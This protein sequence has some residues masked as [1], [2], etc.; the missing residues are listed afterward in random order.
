MYSYQEVLEASKDYFNG[1][2]LSAKVFVDKYALRNEKDELLELTPDDMHRRLAKEFA[3]IE[4][5]K[6]K[7][8]YTE[9]QIYQ[10]FKNY[11]Q[12]IP[13]GSPIYGIG[14]PY[15]LTS[16]SNCFVLDEPEDSYGG[17]LHV[18]EQL[19]HISKRRG[20]VGISLN[21]LR[22]KGSRTHNAARSSTGIKSWMTRYSNSIREVGQGGRRGAL[23]LTLNIHHPDIEDFIT[24]KNDE[25]SVTGANISVQLTDEFLTAVQNDIEYEQRFPINAI[26]PEISIKVKA[27]D[28]WKKIIHNAWMRA[29]PGLQ[30]IDNVLRES[31]ADC[32]WMDGYRTITSNPCIGGES[33][34]ITKEYGK[35]PFKLLKIG[36]EIWS[37]TGWTKVINKKAT[38]KHGLYKISTNYGELYCTEDHY[39]MDNGQKTRMAFT[40][41]IDCFI[42]DN[43]NSNDIC[44]I[45][46]E[47]ILSCEFLGEAEVFDITVD[48]T[49]NT[50]WCGG[51]NVSNCG[52]LFLSVLDSCRLLAL[53][54]F[55]CVVNPFQSNAYFDYKK[56]YELSQIGQRLMDNLVDL[57]L[58]CIDK[59]LDKVKSD[60]EP[61]EIRQRE[62]D[63]WTRIR[64]TCVNGRRTGLGI[65][66]LGD[67]LAALGV[68]YGSPESIQI[69][70]EIY[71]ALKFGSYRSSVDMAKELG[72]FPIW[73]WQKEKDNPFINR[74]KDEVLSLSKDLTYLDLV[75]GYD[76]YNDI[77]KYGRRNIAD[78]TT[79]PTGTI[80]TQASLT[81]NTIK[82]FDT[83]KILF[84]T[85]SGIEPLF[86][87][88]YIR[89][90]K[91]NP[92]DKDFRVDF[93]D[94]TGDSWMEFP[95]YHSGVKMWMDITGETDL[96]KCPYVE[97]NDVIWTERV[98]M[99][100]AA[101]K[102]VDHSISV[103][104][105]LPEDITEE[106]V[107]KIYE[108]AWK[109]G[110]KGFT[111]YR[112][113][114]RSGVLIDINKAAKNKDNLDDRPK[115]LPC[116][117]YHTICGGKQYFVL[118]GMLNEKPYEVF[119]GKNGFISKDVT[120][121]TIIK[122]AKRK[123]KVVFE[124]G[125]ELS[126]ITAA[127]SEYE[128]TITRLTSGLLRAGADI[129]TIVQQLERVNG[130]MHSF[131]KGLARVLKKYIPDGTK[132][133]GET[134]PECKQESIIRSEGCITCK[135]CS[136]S[137]C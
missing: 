134:C 10:W 48:N 56:L 78:L 22:P 95:V 59:I 110:C 40:K 87:T 12:I 101:Q 116:N 68:K 112:E 21:K 74:I 114:C 137:K 104:C 84:N 105:N 51:C 45:K 38:G 75:N 28:V 125:E 4:S 54:L 83:F 57:E 44:V 133:K 24:A 1:E 130:D 36:D 85:T 2:E 17:I 80:S 86:K 107:A 103:T 69:T 20:G 127:T 70:E 34:V 9:D 120:K 6:F 73:D 67:T 33:L 124:D 94:K 106:E 30:F 37:E 88:H 135:N 11:S 100:A 108:E 53:N 52:E 132:E 27:R 16:I 118:V 119:S 26:Q 131:A 76:L 15:Q 89:R 32:Y 90:K 128:E 77:Q 13:Q 14:N 25:T 61:L 102:H 66:V 79:A 7:E 109:S 97:A 55:S 63:T 96:S 98:K 72:P 8:P 99:Q 47:K 19:V 46:N 58:E 71:K 49:T 60:P 3:R 42:D 65:T 64:E 113:N 5:K 115:E 81:L 111:I 122:V 62:I 29:E 39:V 93:V 91:G 50:F 126:P 121:G 82:P 23:M 35:I 41:T 123:Y 43:T 31:P 129:Q 117:V 92:G 136:W 18:D